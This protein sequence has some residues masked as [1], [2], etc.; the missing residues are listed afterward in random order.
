MNNGDSQ[1]VKV[2]LSDY[3]F[4]TDGEW[5]A[6]EIP[7]QDLVDLGLDIAQ[8]TAP[9]VLIGQSGEIG[10]ILLVDAVYL[11]QQ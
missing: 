8:V 1:Q 5:Y 11:N 10:D 4:K 9:L 6:L 2:S 7:L 3:G